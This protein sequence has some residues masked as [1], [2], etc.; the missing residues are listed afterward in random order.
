M[1]TWFLL[2][3]F[4]TSILFSHYFLRDVSRG[5]PLETD[6]AADD[7]DDVGGRGRKGTQGEAEKHTR[8]CITPPGCLWL[9]L[10]PPVMEVVPREMM[11]I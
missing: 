8:G 2:I 9:N 7:K 10:P 4:S 5:I 3:V 1:L 11:V 6:I